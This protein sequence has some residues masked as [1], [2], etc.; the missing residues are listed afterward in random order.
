VNP[1][2]FNDSI[3]TEQEAPRVT[4]PLDYADRIAKL[5][6]AAAFPMATDTTRLDNIPITQLRELLAKA[7]REGYVN[8]LGVTG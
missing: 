4:F 5:Q 1:H 2:T 8:G 3:P 7:A 6:V